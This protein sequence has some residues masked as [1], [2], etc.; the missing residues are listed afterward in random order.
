MKTQENRK[1]EQ[2]DIAEGLFQSEKVIPSRFFYDDKG[3]VLFTKIMDLPE[4]YL[5][6]S[7]TEIFEGFKAQIL[8]NITSNTSKKIELI[9]LGAGDGAK[10][11]I[12]LK[13]LLKEGVEF[14]YV[15][16]DISRNALDLL[17][18]NLS[19]LE[20]LDIQEQCGDYFKL[21]NDLKANEAQKFVLFLGSN[22]GNM[23]DVA[24]SGFL[25]ELA[26]S[27]KQDD[28]LL[29]GVDLTKDESIVLPAYNDKQGITS[30]FNLN[31]LTRM[32]R[33]LEADFDVNKFSHNPEYWKEGKAVSFLVS[34]EAQTV[35]IKSLNEVVTF[36]K[37]EKIRTEI[38]RKY[39][40]D[41]LLKILNGTGFQIKDKFSD[42]KEYF[43][44]YLLK[45]AV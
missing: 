39:N 9:E 5:T 33:E 30:A 35:F 26:A 28:Q 14:T 21:L 34:N 31:L 6:R 43:T 22:L 37:G 32:N 7:E 3:D 12:L 17:L 36:E 41:I 18:D 40:D 23:D 8:N 20:G 10:T 4:Y 13:Y 2:M 24:A 16:I 15:P 45:L 44:D 1:L 19:D 25:K 29:L 27:L 42:E 11:R 38:S